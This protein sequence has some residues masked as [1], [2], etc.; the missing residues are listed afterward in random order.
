[1]SGA[2]EAQEAAVALHEALALGVLAHQ[3]G[4]QGA[5][6]AL[7]AEVQAALEA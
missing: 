5:V 1:V 2:A 7:A 4:A 3:A 6:G